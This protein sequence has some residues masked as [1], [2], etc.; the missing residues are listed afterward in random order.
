MASGPEAPTA[1]S[2]SMSCQSFL[3]GE[4]EGLA[5]PP[6][7]VDSAERCEEHGESLSMFCLDDLEPLCQ[8]CSAVSHE[9]HRVY[10]L[11]EAATDCKVG[12]RRQALQLCKTFELH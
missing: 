5:A 12:I 7:S 6:W 3:T 2:A 10:L 1:T 4:A 11:T 9:G 8:Q